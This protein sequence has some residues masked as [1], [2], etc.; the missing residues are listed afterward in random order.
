MSFSISFKFCIESYMSNIFSIMS[1]PI[2]I[3]NN[4]MLST[5]IFLKIKDFWSILSIKWIF[6]KYQI[7][8]HRIYFKMFPIWSFLQKFQSIS[9]LNLSSFVWFPCFL[10]ISGDFR[11]NSIIEDGFFKI[12]KYKFFY[13]KI[14]VRK[15]KS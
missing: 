5:K 15:R 12:I 14:L 10:H 2:L 4:S 6:H 3:G 1:K 8:L 11:E 13:C 9:T 7:S